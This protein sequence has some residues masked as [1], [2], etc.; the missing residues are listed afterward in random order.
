MDATRTKVIT[1]IRVV[2]QSAP[3]AAPATYR[4][5][6]TTV[7]WMCITAASLAVIYAL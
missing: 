7:V 4:L 3:G 2:E 6:A 5:K 1:S